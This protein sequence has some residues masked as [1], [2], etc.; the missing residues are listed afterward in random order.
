M[1]KSDL[2]AS[3]FLS[4][5]SS[6]KKHSSLCMNDA[7]LLGH[8]HASSLPFFSSF[9]E[10]N[11]ASLEFKIWNLSIFFLMWKELSMTFIMAKSAILKM[12]LQFWRTIKNDE[13]VRVVAFMLHN[14]CALS[15]IYLSL[16]IDFVA[17]ELYNN[18]LKI[19]TNK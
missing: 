15:T 11:N 2:T 5:L 9:Q 6:Q 8:M 17:Y 16:L 1:P 13:D 4:I 14:Y 7:C 3:L 10:W 18:G 12:K 19:K